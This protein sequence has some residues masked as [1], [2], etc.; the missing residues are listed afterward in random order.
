M[1]KILTILII[2]FL[3]FQCG[4]DNE[5]NSNNT[6]SNIPSIPTSDIIVYITKTGECYHTEDC[7][8]LRKSKIEKSLSDV[9]ERYRPC[10][11]CYPPIIDE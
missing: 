5:P 4:C 6:I 2:C 1:K 11:L 8:A 7:S 10:Q 9:A 3:I